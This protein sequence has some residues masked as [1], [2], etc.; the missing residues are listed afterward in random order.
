MKKLFIFIY[1]CLFTG[2]IFAIDFSNLNTAYWY[3][4]E[5]PIRFT[6]RV[7]QRL[8]EVTVFISVTRSLPGSPETSLLLQASYLSTEERLLE[9]FS[10]DT[11]HENGDQLMLNLTFKEVPE[12]LLVIVFNFSGSLYYFPIALKRGKLNHASFYPVYEHGLPI[13]T[14]YLNVSNVGFRTVIQEDTLCFFQYVDNF[15]PADPPTGIAQSVSSTLLIDSVFCSQNSV[16]VSRNH[17]Y[18]IQ[19]DTLSASGL[20]LFVGASYFP[21]LRLIDE[22]VMPLTYFTSR[23]EINRIKGAADAQ[24]QFELFWLKIFNTPT[25]ASAAIRNYYRGIKKANELFTDYKE[26]WK[27]DR[28]ML[29]TTFGLPNAVYHSNRKE[30]WVYGD[31]RFEFKIISNLFAPTMFVLVREKSYEKEWIK[32]I[33]SLRSGQL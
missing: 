21:D 27:T 7:V 13:V 3:D 23:T 26:G 18:F 33:T 2:V 14:S 6:S 9:T 24:N 15:E 5:A 31:L 25:L 11:L 30:I 16:D 19:E 10:L 12:E 32:K 17:F 20:T 22:L 1:A 28:G 29:Y 4:F 8:D